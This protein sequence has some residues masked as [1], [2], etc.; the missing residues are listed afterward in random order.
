MEHKMHL[1]AGP[2]NLVKS[3]KKTIEIRIYDAKRRKVKV[4]DTIIFEELS[5]SGRTVKCRVVGLSI[6][7]SFR[8]LFIAFDKSKFGHPKSITLAEQLGRMHS[9]YTKKEEAKDGVLG[10]H[11]KLA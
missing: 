2:F 5:P 8:D 9:I 10:I 1:F 11:I 4:G 3:G 7:K 6:F